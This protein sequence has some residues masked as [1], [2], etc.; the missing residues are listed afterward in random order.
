MRRKY[1]S[2]CDI[3]NTAN[4]LILKT[5]VTYDQQFTQPYSQTTVT[6]ALSA[7]LR[8]TETETG[9]NERKQTQN[10]I[11]YIDNKNNYVHCFK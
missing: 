10:V 8:N 2:H 3:S 4:W 7:L 1:E 6:K 9:M 5:M 11:I